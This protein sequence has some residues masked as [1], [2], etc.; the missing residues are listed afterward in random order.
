MLEKKEILRIIRM[1]IN[2]VMIKETETKTNLTETKTNLTETHMERKARPI[3]T[4]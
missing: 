2:R 4:T 3:F 1:I